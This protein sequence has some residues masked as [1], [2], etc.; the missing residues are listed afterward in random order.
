MAIPI[1]LLLTLVAGYGTYLWFIRSLLL[2]SDHWLVSVGMALWGL[3]MIGGMVKVVYELF[4]MYRII[5]KLDPIVDPS[6]HEHIQRNGDNLFHRIHR[7]IFYS[8]SASWE[9][10]N[11]RL[12]PQYDFSQLPQRKR[13]LLIAEFYSLWTLVFSMLLGVG[14][15][16]LAQVLGH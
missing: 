8:S 13:I 2:E 9:C 14:A 6:L 16:K 4:M 11:R 1:A 12:M 10:I 5:P 7:A 3:F 15:F